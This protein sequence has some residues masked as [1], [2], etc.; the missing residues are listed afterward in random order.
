MNQ[1][2]ALHKI[3]LL[4]NELAEHNYKYYVLAKPEISDY[5]FDMKLK[6]LEKLEAEFPQFFDPNSP[7]Q[8]VGSDINNDFEQIEHKYSM[9]S[10]ANAY[11]EDEISDFDTRIKKIGTAWMPYFS[12]LKE[13]HKQGVNVLVVHEPTFYTHWDLGKTGYD[14][15]NAPSPA[16]DQYIEAVEVKK[17]WIEDNAIVI[18]RSH[19]IPDIL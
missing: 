11:S 19:D 15:Y 5:E 18:I 16:K 14:F 6:E 8:R 17:K 9:L 4:R 10:L 7:T 3:T 1:E 2:E 13:A 12:T